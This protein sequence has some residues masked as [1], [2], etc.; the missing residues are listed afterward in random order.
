MYYTGQ[1]P[2]TGRNIFVEKEPGKKEQQ[3]KALL[4]S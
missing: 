4:R 2:F 3:K 1:D